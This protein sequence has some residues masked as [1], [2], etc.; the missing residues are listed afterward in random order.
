MNRSNAY[1]IDWVQALENRRMFA[2]SPQTLAME[3]AGVHALTVGALKV[4]PSIVGSYSGTVTDS[5]EK[6][7]G[8]ITTVI[9]KESASGKITG[10]EE[11]KY[12]HEHTH[13][14]DFTGK[15]SGDSLVLT[16]STTTI[17]VAISDNGHVLTGSYTFKTSDDSSTGHFVVTRRS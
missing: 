2:V 4:T 16:T 17:K 14:T 1:P 12:P 6:S 8:T 3:L 13:V 15:I 11:S 9:E 7:P 5:N 10:Y